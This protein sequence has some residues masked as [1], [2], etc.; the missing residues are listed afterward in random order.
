MDLPGTPDDLLSQ[1][2]RARLFEALGELRRPAGTEELAARLG[3]HPNGVRVHLERLREGGLVTRERS[4]GQRGGPR[5][6]WAGRSTT[7]PLP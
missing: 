3:L 6:R 7:H 5:E 4:R 1:P 2:T